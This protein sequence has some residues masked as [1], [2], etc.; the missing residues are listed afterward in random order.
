[1]GGAPPELNSGVL[2]PGAVYQHTFEGMGGVF[3]YHCGF[4]PSTN[5]GTVVCGWSAYNVDS[6]VVVIDDHGFTPVTAYVKPGGS[7]RWI[8][9]GTNPH[10][11]TSD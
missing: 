9:S 8:Q 2:L 11:V 7:V 1:M 5:K 10:T 4:Q 3:P 6:V